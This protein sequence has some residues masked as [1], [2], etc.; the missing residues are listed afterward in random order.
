MYEDGASA[1]NFHEEVEKIYS[2]LY[3]MRLLT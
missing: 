2:D 1:G 3:T